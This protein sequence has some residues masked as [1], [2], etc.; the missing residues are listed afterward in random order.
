MR[1]P[2]ARRGRALR[3]APPVLPVLAAALVAAAC[4]D[5]AEP[6]PAPGPSP[7]SATAEG[8][9]VEV[10]FTRGEEPVPVERRIPVGV[11]PLAG[12][13]EAL[14]EGPTEAER[15][16]GLSSWFS[17]ETAGLFVRATVDGRGRATIDFRSA[18]ARVIPNASSSAGSAALLAELNATVFQFPEVRSVEYRFDGSCE[19]FWNWLQ[20]ACRIVPRPPDSARAARRA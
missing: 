17:Q 10:Y 20:R 13:L 6:E 2:G 8:R 1:R 14:L 11:P 9:A 7:P 12:A 3:P 18:L 19:G 15:E 4:G 5:D 16:R